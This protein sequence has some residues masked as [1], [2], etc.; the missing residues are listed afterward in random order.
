MLI[1]PIDGFEHILTYAEIAAS[2]EKYRRQ[3]VVAGE[4]PDPAACHVDIHHGACGRVGRY[5]MWR[6]VY[7]YR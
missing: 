5:P 7:W 2:I 4:L 1:L 6:E 3:I